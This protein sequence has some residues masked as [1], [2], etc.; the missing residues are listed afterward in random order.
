MKLLILLSFLISLGMSETK[1]EACI[2]DL[3]NLQ[4]LKVKLQEDKHKYEQSTY[5]HNIYAAQLYL[6]F[7]KK[8]IREIKKT[9]DK[10]LV[11]CKDNISENE[12]S[13]LRRNSFYDG[14]LL[15]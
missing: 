13:V 5:E 7:T 14:K 11:N 1:K 15:K 12:L 3:K 6:N 9:V 4:E 2:K 8:D 10:A